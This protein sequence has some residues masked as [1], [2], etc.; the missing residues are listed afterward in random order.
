[1]GAGA[2]ENILNYMLRKNENILNYGCKENGKY[3]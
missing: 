3:P 1:M 2:M